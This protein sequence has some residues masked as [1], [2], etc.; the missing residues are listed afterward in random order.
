MPA[1]AS[2]YENT[3]ES[4]LE[5]NQEKLQGLCDYG[6]S[7]LPSDVSERHA[8]IERSI[9]SADEAGRLLADA[10]SFLSQAQAKAFLHAKTLHPK[11]SPGELKFIVKNAV[12]DIQ[13]LVDG[14]AVTKS[15]LDHR[16]YSSL[17]AN[18]SRL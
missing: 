5:K 1:L 15:T 11:F 12:A 8:D 13:R 9:H 10:E 3:L 7:A 6:L 14:I 16:I 17:N 2:E 4:W 18:R